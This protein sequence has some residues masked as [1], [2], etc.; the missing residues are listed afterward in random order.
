MN[1]RLLSRNLI[2]PIQI[3]AGAV[4]A[5]AVTA[6]AGGPPEQDRE[7]ILAMAGEFEVLFNFRETVALHE[8]YK[9]KDPYR[10]SATEAIVVVEDSPERIVLQHLLVVA[11]GNRVVKHWKQI[12]TWE[13]RRI[14]EY[15]GRQQWKVR[16]LAPEKIEETWSQLV[17]QVDDSPR[18]ESYGTWKHDGGYS[19][20]ESGTTPRPLPRRE[21][22]KRDDYQILLATNRH[23]LTP[24]GWA[25]EQDNVKQIIDENGE[26]AGYIAR[27][28]GTNHY[29][30]TGDADF[31]KA[32]KYWK[33]TRKFWATVSRF[34][35][36]VEKNRDAF[37]IAEEVD[38]KSLTKTMNEIAQSLV[39]QDKAPPGEEKVEALIEQYLN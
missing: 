30:R 17:T 37:A 10:E 2:S 6:F 13:D 15:H 12:W 9:L 18:Y 25:H 19:R 24:F 39:N 20:W 4:L 26:V 11:G 34:W 1:N 14:V 32:R 31:T 27:E 28:I 21:H 22:I 7:A 33:E 36:D 35:A 38:G 29:D 8:D 23:S 5:A 3:I 16:E